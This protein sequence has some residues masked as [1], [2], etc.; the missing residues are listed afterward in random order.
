[1]LLHRSIQQLLKSPKFPGRDYLIEKLPNWFLKSASGEVVVKTHFGFSIHLDP[2]FD[3][4]IENVIYERGVYEQGTT[5]YIRQT[6]KAGNCFVDVGANIGY[7]S[8]VAAATVGPEGT[9][10]AFEPVES[11]FNIL[12]KNKA[13]NSFQHIQLHQFALGNSTESLTIYPEKE[14]RGGASITNKRS[15]QGEEIDVKRLDDL[16]IGSSIDMLKVDVEGFEWEVLKGAAKTIEKD[17]PILIVE[18][19]MDRNNSG[20]S[21]DMLNWLQTEFGYTAYR[22][23]KGKERRSKLAP[24][25]SKTVGLPE[26]DNIICLP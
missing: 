12:E 23:L 11:T 9:V 15:E 8:L 14:N 24:C 5:E 7:L 19:S 20:S 4:N 1:M 22:F 10:L 16:K 25:V 18:Y 17:R 21:A 6:L 13:L 26:H 3:K 2:S